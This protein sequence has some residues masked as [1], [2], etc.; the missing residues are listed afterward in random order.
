MKILLT[1][2]DGQLGQAF[3]QELTR[4][5]I[6]YAGTDI[7]TCDITSADQ[8][9]A[10]LDVQ[11]P[12][13]LINC[14]A[15]NLVDD[16]EQKRDL[17]FAVNAGA[18]AVLTKA[19]GERGIQFVHYS[20]DY[21]FD[22]TKYELYTEDDKPA[23]L[24]VYGQSKYEGEQIACG[25]AGSLVFRTS[26]VY[27]DGK[28]SFLYK[29]AEWAQKNKVLR[30]SA[31]EVS[32]PTSAHDLVLGTLAALEQKMQGLYHLTS[33]GYASRY[34]LARYF[35]KGIGY[36]GLV[37]PVPLDYFKPKVARPLFSAM[38]NKRFCVD[39]QMDIPHWHCGV[40][41]YI[42]YIKERPV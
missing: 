26:W 17:A 16:A 35:L 30:I 37:I 34:E 22:G 11:R 40:D 18:V 21:V 15:Y 8:V 9:A 31:D 33:S 5:G 12:T 1:G 7:K 20:T 13:V 25:L 6:A 24:N 23:P 2:A 32:V 14:A 4:R 10:L 19:A 42:R 29:V 3:I 39:A 38:T 41:T 27:G 36:E 28:Q